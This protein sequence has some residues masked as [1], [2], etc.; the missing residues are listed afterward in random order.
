[1]K[2]RYNEI[3]IE[4][5]QNNSKNETKIQMVLNVFKFEFHLESFVCLEVWLSGLRHW[6]ARHFPSILAPAPQKKEEREI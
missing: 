1:M 5:I 2:E 4:P 3:K 6:F